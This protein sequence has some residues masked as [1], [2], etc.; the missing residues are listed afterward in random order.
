MDDKR[1]TSKTDVIVDVTNIAGGITS[2]VRVVR[3]LWSL[4]KSIR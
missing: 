3:L 1:K 4:F 2:A